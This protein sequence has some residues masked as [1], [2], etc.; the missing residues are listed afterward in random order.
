MLPFRAHFTF[1]CI[2]H[3]IQVKSPVFI[4]VFIEV[5]LKVVSVTSFLNLY[6]MCL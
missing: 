6:E 1:M 2:V 5:T 3:F 4:D